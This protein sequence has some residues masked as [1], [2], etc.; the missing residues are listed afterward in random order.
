MTRTGAIQCEKVLGKKG[1]VLVRATCLN[2]VVHYICPPGFRTGEEIS[3]SH[4][5]T[6]RRI[7][8]C[9]YELIEFLFSSSWALDN[10]SKVIELGGGFA[11]LAG[12]FLATRSDQVEMTLTDGA[13]PCV[14][15]LKLNARLNEFAATTSPLRVDVQQVDWT[16]PLPVHL[17]HKYDL[18]LV[19]DCLYP[20]SPPRAL[21]DAV[22]RLLNPK[23]RNP[24]F[25]LCH[26]FRPF[27]R[28]NAQVLDLVH[29]FGFQLRHVHST[30]R[31]DIEIFQLALNN[32]H[33]VP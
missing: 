27:R 19:A 15:Y 14:E 2:S 13:A 1:R 33:A 18:V 10:V 12:L 23:A 11:A 6:G 32:E 30:G 26:Q 3:Q 9:E 20:S 28:Y 29:E 22:R 5:P 25:L 16:Q 8:P 24:Q 7:W 21:F 31:S 17:Q 4:D